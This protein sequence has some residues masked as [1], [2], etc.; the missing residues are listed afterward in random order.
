MAQYDLGVCYYYGYGVP[1]DRNEAVRWWRKAA[2][3]EL[4]EARRALKDL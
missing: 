2:E 4:E 3:Q 1:E